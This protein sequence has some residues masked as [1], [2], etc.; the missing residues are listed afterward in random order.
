MR[1][2]EAR[3]VKG[4]A[5]KDAR[6]DE[7]QAV[8]GV[9]LE[10]SAHEVARLDRVG[11]EVDRVERIERCREHARERVERPRL[12]K[13]VEGLGSEAEGLC[14]QDLMLVVE[15]TRQRLLMAKQRTC[16]SVAACPAAMVNV[17]PKWRVVAL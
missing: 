17:I 6:L 14:A 9:R 12:R 2:C 7:T 10:P 4:D 8:L 13:R 16:T 11:M 15:A 5:R 3:V 1:L